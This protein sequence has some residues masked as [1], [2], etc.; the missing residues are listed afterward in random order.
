[1]PQGFC[2]LNHSLTSKQTA[3]LQEIFDIQSIEYPPEDIRRL[4]S[5]LPVQPE[6][7][8]EPLEK[9]IRWLHEK[10]ISSQDV[11]V[12]QGE[13]GYSF[14]LVDYALNNGFIPIHSVTQRIAAETVK[15]EIVQT[16]YIFEHISFRRYRRYNPHDGESV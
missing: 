8:A 2:L 7:S 12:I 4:W 9:I 15:D 10:N 16:H 13:A 14:A 5:N 3:E 11:I 6:I 1:M